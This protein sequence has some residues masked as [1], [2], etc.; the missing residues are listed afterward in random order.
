M[1]EEVEKEKSGVLHSV[2][3]FFDRILESKSSSNILIVVLVILAALPLG[4]IAFAAI[5]AA[6]PQD[7]Q[8]N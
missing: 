1:S 6:V 3:M 7:V 2:A 4:G 5:H 8:S